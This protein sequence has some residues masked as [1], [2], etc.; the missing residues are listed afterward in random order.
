MTSRRTAL[1]AAIFVVTFVAGLFLVNNPDTDASPATFADF[2]AKS[3]NRLH[4][5]LAAVLL[6]ASALAW[7][8]TVN[9]LRERLGDC[10]ASRVATTAAAATAA[11]IGVAGTMLAIIPAAMVFG[12][13]PAPGVD[14]ARFL[15]QAGYAALTLFAMPTA[16]L[17][18]TAIGIGALRTGALPRWLAY[19]GFAASVVLLASLE[20]F[21]M[22]LFVVWVIATAVV[23]AR[24]PLRIPLPATA[25]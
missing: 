17:T 18:V 11:L 10:V 20:F 2:Y 15:P 21:P 8:V 9:G 6:S 25:V 12:S 24:R 3:G 16:A 14:L 13:A 22:L 19:L 5:I 4:L 1:A 7:I 23:L